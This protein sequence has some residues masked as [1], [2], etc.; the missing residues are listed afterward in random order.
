MVKGLKLV[1][2]CNGS[3]KD[4]EDALALSEKG[5]L[6]KVEIV[7]LEYL[8]EALDKLKRGEVSGRQAV[9]FT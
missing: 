7:K 3:N 8:D 1:A 5:I 2:Q 6:P 9:V 4:I